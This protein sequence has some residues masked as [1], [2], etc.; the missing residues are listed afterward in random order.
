[1][2][3]LCLPPLTVTELQEALAVEPNSVDLDTNA[4]IDPDLFVSACA[5]LVAI[6]AKTDV[7]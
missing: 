2:D 1:M 5:G 7:I 3:F 4:F 6:D